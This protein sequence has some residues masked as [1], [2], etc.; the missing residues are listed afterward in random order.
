MIGERLRRAK[1][2]RLLRQRA[3]AVQPDNLP[4]RS[5]IPPC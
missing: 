5:P 4:V 3:V 1:D 2:P